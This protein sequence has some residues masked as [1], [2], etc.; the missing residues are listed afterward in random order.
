MDLLLGKWK[1]QDRGEYLQNLKLKNG[2]IFIKMEIF[3]KKEHT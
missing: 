3:N 1:Y 2:N